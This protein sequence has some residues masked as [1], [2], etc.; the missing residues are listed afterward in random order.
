MQKWKVQEGVCD[1]DLFPGFEWVEQID[2]QRVQRINEFT[3]LA[4]KLNLTQLRDLNLNSLP[5]GRC[6]VI[7]VL[8]EQ[9]ESNGL[10]NIRVGHTCFFFNTKGQQHVTEFNFLLRIN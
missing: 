8:Q 7:V 6:D 5:R 10:L 3:A 4:A 9:T 1:P 2:M